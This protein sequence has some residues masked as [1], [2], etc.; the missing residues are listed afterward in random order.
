MTLTDN[1]FT[2]SKF[3][4]SIATDNMFPTPNNAISSPFERWLAMENK[5]LDDISEAEIVV[6]RMPESVAN[7]FNANDKKLIQKKVLKNG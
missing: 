1:P 3:A 5:T 2:L 4:V 7:E 6:D